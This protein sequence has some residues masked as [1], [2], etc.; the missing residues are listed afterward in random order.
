M[1]RRDIIALMG[2]AA[3][4]PLVGHAQQPTMPVIGFVHLGSAAPMAPQVEGFREGLAEA[5]FVE[6]QNLTIEYRWAEGHFDRLPAFVADLLQRHVNILVAGGGPQPALA[7]KASTSKIPILFVMADDPVKN[8]LVASFNRPGGNITG[9]AFLS[10]ALVAKRL[11]LARELVP[12]AISIAYLMNPDELEN[13]HEAADF[14]A[15]GRSVGQRTEILRAR[16]GTDLDAVFAVLV[17]PQTK[18]MIVG[19]NVSFVVLR[20]HLTALA[21]RYAIPTI[22]GLREFVSAGGLASYGA[23]VSD[24]Y[25]Q[26]GRYA[27]RIMK[28]EQ[29]GELPVVQPTRFE[30]V[31][32]RKTAN[33]IG[34]Q[35]PDKLL[36]LADEVIE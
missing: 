34:L 17:Q 1:R 26:I 35:I 5:G 36:A 18:A 16:N 12:A 4:W 24:A 3:A 20:D 10:A 30:F 6:Q 8:G 9:A 11:D 31:I 19:T 23:S 27:G 2:S 13:E 33:A 22:Y 32:N 28:G 25:R 21:A 29:P 15:A 7:A 14:E